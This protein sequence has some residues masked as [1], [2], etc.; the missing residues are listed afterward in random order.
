M[1]DEAQVREHQFARGVEVV[2]V[3]QAPGERLLV[4]DREHRDLVHGADVGVE[5]TQGTGNRQVVRHQGVGTQGHGGLG[6]GGDFSNG[7]L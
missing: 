6:H 3:A 5:R 1:D 2:V 7:P 4:L